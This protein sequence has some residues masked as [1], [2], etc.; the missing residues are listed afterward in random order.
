MKTINKQIRLTY[1]VV[2]NFLVFGILFFLYNYLKDAIIEANNDVNII[3]SG[4]SI[5]FMVIGMSIFGLSFLMYIFL[6]KQND[7]LIEDLESL[8]EHVQDISLKEYSSNINI[9]HYSD[10]LHISLALKNIV[11]RLNK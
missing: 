6:K 7:N 2:F 4:V 5:V 11:K 10:F 8:S 9:K 3:F 1:V